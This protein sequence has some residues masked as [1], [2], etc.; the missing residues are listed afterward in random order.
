MAKASVARAPR[1]SD[2]DELSFAPPQESS[3]RCPACQQSEWVTAFRV[4]GVPISQC[5]QCGLLA[6]THFVTRAKRPDGLYDV[7]DKDFRDYCLQYQ[8]SRLST[9]SRILP[10]LEPF[11]Y[12]GRL[13]EIGSGYGDFLKLASAANW[14]AQGVE[15]SDYC[16][17]VARR[18]GC[19][20]RQGKLE[21]FHFEADSFDVI[22]LWDVIEHFTEPDEIIARCSRLLRPGGALVMRTPDAR[23]LAPRLHPVRAAYRHLAYPANTAQHVFHFTPDDLTAIVAN[24]QLKVL[25]VSSE[26]PWSERVISANQWPVAIARWMIMRIAHWRGWPYEFVLTATKPGKALVPAA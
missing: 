9:Y 7:D 10:Q 2:P 13:L 3:L 5:A 15:I 26:D 23:A 17:R 19:G 22:A 6:T 8:P 18:Q 1:I 12:T 14:N 21:D 16:C 24:H 20:V 4:R 25:D 11:R